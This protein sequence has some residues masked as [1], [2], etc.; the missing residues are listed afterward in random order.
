MQTDLDTATSLAGM[1]D[2]QSLLMDV[3]SAAGA[4]MVVGVLGVGGSG[5]SA[6]LAAAALALRRNGVPVVTELPIDADPGTAL[7]LDDLHERDD[8]HLA[9]VAAVISRGD[10]TVMISSEPRDHRPAIASLLA[11]V[12][13]HGRVVSLAPISAAGVVARSGRH[14]LAGPAGVIARMTGGNRGAVDSALAAMSDH[15][16]EGDQRSVGELATVAISSWHHRALRRLDP[17]A[18]A[19]LVI[20]SAG[21]V[22]DPDTVALTCDIDRDLAVH[23]IDRARGS[24]FLT[25]ADRLSAD[26]G[27]PLRAVTGARQ[28]ATIRNALIRVL[29]SHN[30]LTAD[31]AL[32]AADEGTVDPILADALIGYA[33]ETTG[34]RAV[35]LLTAAHTAGADPSVINPALAQAAFDAD[36]LA[37]AARIADAALA[38]E[39]T[40]AVRTGVRLAASIAA[41]QGTYSRAAQLFRWLGAERAGDDAAVGVVALVGAGDATAARV[42]ADAASHNAP[43]TDNASATL[44]AGGLLASLGSAVA[45]ALGAV[46]RAASMR[47]ENAVE[48]ESAGVI[49]VLLNLHTGDESGALAVLDRMAATQSRSTVRLDLLRAW[50]AMVRGDLAE[51]SAATATA[52][53]LTQRDLLLQHALSVAIARRRG[54]FGGLTN[55]WRDAQAVVA[56]S[57]ADL[58][59]LLPLGELWLAA[60]RCGDSPRVAHLAA[61]ASRLLSDL[62]DPPVW[63]AAWH[64]YGVQ[65]AILAN[66]PSALVPH[67][68]ALGVAAE[69]SSYAAVLAQAGRVWL[70]VLQGDD[71]P[72]PVVADDIDSAARNLHRVGHAFD[73]ARLAAEGALR[74]GDTKSATSLLQTARTIGPV[75]QTVPTIAGEAGSHSSLSEREAEVA[76]QLVLGLTYREIGAALFISAKTVEHHVARIR[77]RLGVGSRSELMSALRAAG[78]GTTP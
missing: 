74:I 23:A 31:R 50:A 39:S 3:E 61:D 6:V 15:R 69:T 5:K 24:G 53:A 17:T 12:R 45:P 52:T 63:S 46:L 47:G 4:P 73:G 1:P 30:L 20:A 38:S 43:T 56:E 29:L 67:A 72:T 41:R 40:A 70:K 65:A 2:A 22:P 33:R 78:Y 37:V 7:L 71:T 9:H 59:S 8:E 27:E 51:A 35:R 62:G 25:D 49:A 66:Q 75:A 54:D 76:E 64:W 77:R 32:T 28:V 55:A 19:V 16:G 10:L 13:T 18:L 42:F 58:F 11:T 26:I 68:R 57:E 34:H 36:D 14:L 44:L 60:V 48:P 21:S